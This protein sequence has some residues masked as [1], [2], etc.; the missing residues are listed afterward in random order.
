MSY[1]KSVELITQLVL[2]RPTG[3]TRRRELLRIW[4]RI[5]ERPWSRKTR[6]GK[7]ISTHGI[8]KGVKEIAGWR[9]SPRAWFGGPGEL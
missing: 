7:P 6:G 9:D 3:I 1:A 4:I 2:N 8:K 5:L